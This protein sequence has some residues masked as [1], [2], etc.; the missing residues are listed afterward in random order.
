L[1]IIAMTANAMSGDREKCLAA[2]MNDHV[3]KPIDPDLLFAAL[4][5]WV[6]PGQRS[7]PTGVVVAPAAAAEPAPRSVVLPDDLPGFDMKAALKGTGGN[8]ELLRQ[9]LLNFLHDHE[10]DARAL[11]KA[12]NEHDMELAQRIAHTLKGLAGAI[13]AHELRPAAIAMDAAIRSRTS[14]SYLRLLDRLENNLTLVT[15]SLKWLA[16]QPVQAAPSGGAASGSATPQQLI[17]RIESLVRDRDPDA[18]EV[19]VALQ[20]LVGASLLRAHA[21]ELV[22]QLGVFDFD[23]ARQTLNQLKL[24]LRSTS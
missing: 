9:I 3:A 12:L 23:A 20:Q 5:T 7:L 24:A 15:H 4:N 22:S 18:E 17:E 6:S 13:G 2:G 8:A 1:P 11:R 21:L 10:G 16:Q 19:A 14:D